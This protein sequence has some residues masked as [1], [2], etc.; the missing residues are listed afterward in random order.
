MREI[1]KPCVA[2]CPTSHKSS[3]R[4]I[5]PFH[6][7][8]VFFKTKNLKSFKGRFFFLFEE[9][10]NTCSLYFKKGLWAQKLVSY[11]LISARQTH[12]SDPDLKKKKSWLN[13]ARVEKMKKLFKILD[14]PW[15]W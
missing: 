10:R 9:S 13:M 2:F 1:E 7:I 4:I 6:H 15:A 14:E 12:F 8:D 11:I 5:F 3:N